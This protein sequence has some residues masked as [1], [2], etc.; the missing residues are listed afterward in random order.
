MCANGRPFA[1]IRASFH[2][3]YLQLV[4]TTVLHSLPSI[5]DFYIVLAT[6]HPR[7][8]SKN[9]NYSLSLIDCVSTSRVCAMLQ[10]KGS[11]AALVHEQVAEQFLGLLRSC[12]DSSVETQNPN[13]DPSASPADFHVETGRL[14][15]A[16]CHGSLLPDNR[17][18][19]TVGMFNQ[20]GL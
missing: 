13:S 1:Y 3:Y 14:Y 15:M 12:Q 18:T 6:G 19:S 8:R 5:T 17:I 20:M 4:G 7:K 11:N 2:L 16:F 9:R 10:W